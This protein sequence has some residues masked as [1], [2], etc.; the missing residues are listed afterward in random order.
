METTGKYAK[1]FLLSSLP[2][3]Y[4]IPSMV[5]TSSADSAGLLKDIFL[6]EGNS[7]QEFFYVVFLNRSNKVTGYYQASMGGVTSTIADPRLIIK[8]AA[9]ADCTSLILC[10]N[11][12]SG[13]LKPSRADEELTK[14]IVEGCAYFDIKVLDH[15]I[16]SEDGY[17]S[18]A[19]EGII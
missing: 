2:T 5:I 15:V 18:F 11:H 9:L 10:H 4:V 12:P 13:S 7:I 16:I 3:D 6:W 19:D 8:A 14:K 17:Y 1:K